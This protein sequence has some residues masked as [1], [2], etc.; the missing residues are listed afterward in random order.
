MG[1]I[2]ILKRYSVK[3]KH[4]Q[5]SIMRQIPNFETSGCK[6]QTPSNFKCVICNLPLEKM[7]H[8]WKKRA[9]FFFFFQKKEVV[10]VLDN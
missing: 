4:L 1:K 8:L 2:Q 3:C 6:I 7:V 10:L 9:D 5:T